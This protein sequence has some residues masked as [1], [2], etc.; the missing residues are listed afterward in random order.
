M[1]TISEVIDELAIAIQDLEV[2]DNNMACIRFPVGEQT[3]KVFV[4]WD[5]ENDDFSLTVRRRD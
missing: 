3:W 5:V 2:D 1:V 4:H